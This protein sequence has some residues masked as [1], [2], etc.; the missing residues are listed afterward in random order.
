MTGKGYKYTQGSDLRGRLA[1]FV[2]WWGFKKKEFMKHKPPPAHLFDPHHSAWV[3]STW[4]VSADR[5]LQQPPRR[6]CTH[7]RTHKHIRTHTHTYTCTHTHAHTYVWAHIHTCAH[8][9]LHIHT[10]P[11]VGL[12]QRSWDLNAHTLAYTKREGAVSDS[13]SFRFWNGP[14]MNKSLFK[15]VFSQVFLCLPNG[16][17][18]KRG[19]S[20]NWWLNYVL[21][22]GKKRE[23]EK[24][25]Q[26]QKK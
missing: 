15:S 25:R 1:C 12:A 13:L 16:W 24:E 6:H 18:C 19:Y 10:V 2:V 5:T 9:H 3:H 14:A 21:R 11:F 7:T 4:N 23:R 8:A 22:V 26:R 17:F 20:D